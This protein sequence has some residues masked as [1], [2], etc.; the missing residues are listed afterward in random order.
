MA[1][2]SVTPSLLGKIIRSVI[3]EGTAEGSLGSPWAVK[4]KTFTG[5][6]LPILDAIELTLVIKH[7]NYFNSTYKMVTTEI[8]TNIY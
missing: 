1:S 2:N 4:R 5:K 3:H 7:R 6:Y 8:T